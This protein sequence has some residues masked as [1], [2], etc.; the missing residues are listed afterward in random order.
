[1]KVKVRAR[2]RVRVG[3]GGGSAAHSPRVQSISST[4]AVRCRDSCMY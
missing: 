4:V 1:M 3:K 2:A